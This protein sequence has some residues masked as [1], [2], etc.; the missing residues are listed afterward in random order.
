MNKLLLQ[1]ILWFG[2]FWQGFGVNPKHLHTILEAKLK[3]DGRRRSAFNYQAKPGKE[4]KGQDLLVMAMFGFFGLVMVVLL[5]ALQHKASAVFI[6]FTAWMIMLALTLISDFTDVL[7]D[8]RDN[9]ILLPRP[10]NNR[11]LTV[12]RLLHVFFY[13]TKLTV[14]FSLPAVLYLLF[15]VGPLQALVFCILIFLSV[16]MT[17]F[18][19]NLTYLIILQLTSPRRFRDIIGYF[20][21]AFYMITILG[22]QII[23]RILD[24]IGITKKV[25]LLDRLSLW[26]FPSMWLAGLWETLFGMDH[27]AG[28]WILA[29]LALLMPLLMV[30]LVSTVLA[31][32]FT[33]KLLAIGEAGSS[34]EGDT[35]TSL[36]ETGAVK[37]SWLAHW[38]G[39]ICRTPI[40]R[41]AYHLTWAISGRSRDF[42]L[43]SYPALAIVPIY[44]IYF[45][46]IGDGSLQDKFQKLLSGTTYI[47]LLYG[48]VLVLTSTWGNVI[49]SDR[50]KAAW[51]FRSVPLPT[52]GPLLLGTF[53]SLIVKFY[54]WYYLLMG[55]VVVIL[56][57]PATLNDILF[58]G[59]NNIWIAALLTQIGSLSLP[60]SKAWEEQA[61]GGNV[62][63]TFLMFTVAG[64]I[65]TIHYF[66]VPFEWLV[67]A[68]IP[69]AGGATWLTLRAI[70]K[71]DWRR[72]TLT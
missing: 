29:G 12:S 26:P 16:I 35:K 52:P 15:W 13:L 63:A 46:V 17:I 18:I 33:S 24:D 47:I 67:W 51:L 6:Y 69:V 31:S 23:P 14:P 61:K 50:Y 58:I 53:L 3:M 71:I 62:A 38:G 70:N 9:Y 7:I 57:G 27:G 2:G 21:I 60:F 28:V 10:V 49:Y 5:V 72:L 36:T 55:I 42:K 64:I 45:M 20:Q 1:S 59:I 34:S 66:I 40:E 65:G 37:T 25:N 30:Y 4:L 19:V 44:F 22:Y 68:L 8:V 32:S 43:K 56:W 41:A 48:A 54:S 11:T 39:K